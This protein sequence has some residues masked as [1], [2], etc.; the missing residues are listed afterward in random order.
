MTQSVVVCSVPCVDVRLRDL[1]DADLDQ[2]FEWEQDPGA[3]AMAAFTRANAA[4]R[5]A[6]DR[7]Y[8]GIRTNPETTLLAIEAD[9]V[10][11]GTIGSYTMDGER[12]VTYWIDP[13]RWGRGV[14]ST[15]LRAFL[16]IEVARPL[17]ARVAAHNVGSAT[18][19]RRAGFVRNGAKT[20]YA[21]GVGR[22]VVEHIYR[23]TVQ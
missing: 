20:A 14:A 5:D 2:L 8:A 15:A 11:A 13:S 3:I 1:D 23:L 9:G 21:D 4:D 22:D 19:L 16:R 10:F 17:S 6:F 18:V 12:E 7:H